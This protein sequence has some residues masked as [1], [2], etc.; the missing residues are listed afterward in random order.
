MLLPALL[1]VIPLVAVHLYARAYVEPPIESSSDCK[2][3]NARPGSRAQTSIAIRP[4]WVQSFRA[5]RSA[6]SAVNFLKSKLIPRIALRYP[7]LWGSRRLDLPESRRAV[8]RR[9]RI[10]PRRRCL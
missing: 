6:I 4:G 3:P 2:D 7:S 10:L 9:G 5:A 1:L 8:R